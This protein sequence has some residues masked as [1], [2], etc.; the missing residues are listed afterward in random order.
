MV[1]HAGKESR[2][3]WAPAQ[4]RKRERVRGIERFLLGSGFLCV[5][6]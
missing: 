3:N 6:K 2:E 5:K 1:E 4:K